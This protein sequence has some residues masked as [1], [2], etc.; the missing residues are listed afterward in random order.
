MKLKPLFNWWLN[1]INEPIE[2]RIGFRANEMSRAK[3]VLE[4]TNDLGLTEFRHII[5]KSKNGKR[6]K[7]DNTGWQKPAFP[8][9]ENGIFKDKVEKY[10]IDKPVRFA[11]MNNCVGCFHREPVLLK[12]MSERHPNKF[13]WF[14][15]IE[16]SGCVKGTFRTGTTYN[17]IKNSF[18][19]TQLF[20]NDFNEC[21][22][23]YCGL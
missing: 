14:A 8:L 21:D 11:Y 15:N 2:M 9:I 19:Q 1:N 23:G 12:H 17:K 22:S 13:D 16:N 4:K 18:K 6:N 5:G 7:W 20:D 3:A 10:W